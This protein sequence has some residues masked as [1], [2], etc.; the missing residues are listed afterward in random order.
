MTIKIKFKLI[1]L[2]P[3]Y[4]YEKNTMTTKDDIVIYRNN[5]R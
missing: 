3:R 1:E 4:M 2:L 5:N